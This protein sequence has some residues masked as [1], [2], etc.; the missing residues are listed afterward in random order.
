M[1][2][3]FKEEANEAL[4]HPLSLF[5][6][7][8]SPTPHPVYAGAR[9]S[10][11]ISFLPPVL[12]TSLPPPLSPCR[13]Q[14]DLVRVFKEAGVKLTL[15]HGRGGT[16]GRGGGP[17]YLAIQVGRGGGHGRGGGPKAADQITAAAEQQG[18][19]VVVQ[20]KTPYST[21]IPPPPQ[22]QPPGSVAGSFRI[23]EQGEMVQAKFGIPAVAEFTM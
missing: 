5:P 20:A 2:H 4:P 8:C 22:S 19:E 11:C 1:K 21:S 13:C 16:V 23:T 17:T 7:S 15:F 6:T 18:N 12:C 10:W 14:E 9:R 3:P